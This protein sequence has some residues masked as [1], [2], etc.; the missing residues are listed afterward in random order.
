[1]AI[2][3]FA[4]GGLA[5]LLRTASKIRRGGPLTPLHCVAIAEPEGLVEGSTTQQKSSKID[6]SGSLPILILPGLGNCTEDYTSLKAS[7]EAR[8]AR[9]VEVLPVQRIDWLRNAAGLL[10]PAYWKGTLQPRPILD[11]YLDRVDALIEEVGED[12]TVI[13]HSAGGWLARVYLGNALAHP[14]QKRIKRLVTLGTPHLPAAPGTSAPDQTR[15]LLTY[16]EREYPGAF[17]PEVEYVCVAGKHR[18]GAF[19]WD[20]LPTDPQEDCG[21][22]RFEK[23]FVGAGYWTVCGTL[24]VWGDSIVPVESALLPNAQQIILQGVYHSP[25]GD[26]SR[27]REWYG[28]EANLDRWGE[29]LC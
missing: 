2:G 5:R 1:M 9:R 18:K 6:L 25:L 22:T 27:A 15:G 3:V 11:W 4:L 23:F 10:D 12:V 14:N 24:E 13:G 8:G 28:A 17:H 26:D 16:I 7:L 20:D 29:A 21:G 19:L